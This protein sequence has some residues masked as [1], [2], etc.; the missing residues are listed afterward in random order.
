MPRST[1]PNPS[2]SEPGPMSRILFV[3]QEAGGVG[4]ST[5]SRALAEAIP[6]APIYEIESSKRLVEL[7]D[8]VEH[9]PIRAERQEVL[10]SGGE[11]ALSEYDE[12]IN[13]LLVG[14]NRPTIVDV[15]ANGATSVLTSFGRMA[16]AFARRRREL[17]VLV[18]V[19]ADESAYA[20]AEKLLVMTK[21]WA[22]A[23]Y[24]LANE[25]RGAV[26]RQRIEGFA[27]GATVTYLQSFNIPKQVRPMV[28]PLGFALIGDI[29][30]EKLATKLL[31]RKGNPNHVMAANVAEILASFRL[32]AMRAVRPA[33][34]W[35]IR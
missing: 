35:M 31:D 9:Y 18:I 8:R 30:E 24:V 3:A 5:A 7:G 16:P 15:G 29:D 1:V 19:A 34:E 14:E 10:E 25:H 20:S 6:D 4:K 12:V 32:E 21:P 13:S 26:D 17:G 33:A 27:A 22:A 2:S 23:Q 28:E 11:A